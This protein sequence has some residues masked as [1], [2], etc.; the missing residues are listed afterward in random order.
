MGELAVGELAMGELVG[1]STRRP[2]AD[3]AAIAGAMR[4][5]QRLRGSR[6]V[7]AAL[8]RAAHI[9]LS[10]QAVQVLLALGHGQSVAELARAAHMDVAAV[11]RQLRVLEDAGL[12]ERAPSPDHGSVVI[13]TPTSRGRAVAERI[14][15]VRD[16]HLHRA[17]AAWTPD[18]REHL[19]ALLQRLVDDLQ[20]TPYRDDPPEEGT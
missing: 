18:D 2:S 6:Q 1:T 7:H 14:R 20:A 9:E 4:A 11:S 15:R 10:Q 12:L 8:V 13:V 3:I 17:L 19:A 16:E 5:L